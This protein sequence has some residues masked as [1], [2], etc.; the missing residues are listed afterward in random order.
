MIY[1]KEY[2]V[3]SCLK[4]IVNFRLRFFFIIIL[5]AP[6]ATT[7]VCA[8]KVSTEE[9]NIAADKVIRYEDP[10]SIVAQGN[11]VLEK[12]E[13]LPPPPPKKSK[14][15]SSWE[16]LLGE[17][18]AEE[19]VLAEQA[20][21]SSA[22]KYQT[23]VT[24]RADWMVYDVELEKIK[25]KGNVQIISGDDIITAKEG[26][27][28]LLDETGEFIDATVIR[29]EKSLHI[30]GKSI[31]KTGFD[32]YKVVDGWVIT[33]K[34]EEGETPPWSLKS[35]KTD[36]QENGYA[37]LKHA[38]F[39]IKDFPILYTPYLI[40]PVKNTRQTGFLFPEFSSS[41]NNGFGFNLPFF[42][43]ISESMD[44]TLFPEFYAKRGFMPG[45][46]FRYFAGLTDKGTFT[47]SYLDDKLSDPS[48]TEYYEDTGYTHDNSDRYWLRGKA[49]HNFGDWQSRLD[50]DIVSDQDYLTE[51]NNG[52]TGFDNSQ[53]R[54]VDDF[55]RGF[56]NRTSALRE[57]SLKVLRTW[58]GISLSASFLGFDDATT[59]ADDEDETVTTTDETDTTTE[60]LATAD[61]TSL[62]K[63][64]SVDFSGTL[65]LG[66]TGINFD[67]N[68]DYVNYW[69]EEGVGGH[70]FDIRPTV[71]ASIPLSVYL[72]S[73][74]EF[75]LR[76]T[77][78]IVEE[79]GDAVWEN[80]DSQ[81]RLIPEFEAEVATTLERDF[82]SGSNTTQR[83]YNHLV[84]PFVTYNYIPDVDQDDLPYF[85]GVDSINDA[86][87]I[88][89]GID[90]AF[91]SFRSMGE[92]D[93]TSRDY[94]YF[95]IQ[96]P[97]DIRDEASDEPFG[98]IYT[99]IGW[100]PLAKARLEYNTYFD[101]YESNFNS[102]SFESSYENS[103]GDLLSIDYSF[104][105]DSDIE[106]INAA[107]KAHL[108]YG[109][110]VGASVEHSISDDETE[111]ASASLTYQALC[112]SVKFQT[113]YTPED[114]TYM[115]LFKLAN[116]GSTLDIDF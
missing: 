18:Q 84:R 52:Y 7:Q 39:R 81:N 93:E 27:L 6:I 58:S 13:N 21:E 75:S 1:P 42:I 110:I 32:T 90:N 105:E 26:T 115:I 89:Y 97:Y 114:T 44:L 25:A 22:P 80:D 74:A 10:S 23:T 73:R 14:S 101:V 85:D 94:G 76:D 35:K 66:D 69:R 30:E 79:Y 56:Q 98:D 57:N 92:G 67:W 19:E 16:E 4:R 112:W 103:R 72:E 88:T 24:I 47:A 2:T 77:Y 64:P 65:P 15:L 48:E 60:A 109:W 111:N 28:N 45:A 78:Y 49:N 55:G 100:Y 108:F 107:I 9:W 3:L 87:F 29:D 51:F 113:K 31:E 61:E 53:K 102:H 36:I 8:E 106:Q 38:T 59:E 71:S 63:L 5:L 46:E 96:Q 95:K 20:E 34:V 37:V 99:R 104:K 40:V 68:A 62:W 86:N 33:C 70:R 12:I 83:S 11:V 43:N 91:T 82:F 54:Y 17:S 41:S 50:V 116:I